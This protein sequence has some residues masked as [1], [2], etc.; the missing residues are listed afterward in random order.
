M[1]YQNWNNFM[2]I[3]NQLTLFKSTQNFKHMQMQSSWALLHRKISLIRGS[4]TNNIAQSQFLFFNDILLQRVKEYNTNSLFNKFTNELMERYQNKLSSGA[5][6]S[7]GGHYS[8]RFKGNQ[9][10]KTNV[11]DLNYQMMSH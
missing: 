5:S 7:F 6:R 9:K 3:F 4:H 8:C 1:N 10:T 2:T 11:Q